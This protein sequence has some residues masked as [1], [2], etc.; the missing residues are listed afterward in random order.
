MI[1]RMKFECEASSC[2]L[3]EGADM[4]LTGNRAIVPQRS[5]VAPDGRDQPV[6]AEVNARARQIATAA[7]NAAGAMKKY[8]PLRTVNPR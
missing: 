8:T 1:W 4:V 5:G 2:F 6:L 3:G 7:E